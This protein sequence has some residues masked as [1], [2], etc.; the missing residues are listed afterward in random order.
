[1][2]KWRN[3]GIILSNNPRNEVEGII[4]QY[5]FTEPDEN[6]CFR[7]IAQV[8]VRA[9]AFSFIVFVSSLQ[10]ASKVARRPF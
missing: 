8:I 1:M 10:L 9:T 3:G 4:R 7:I 6:N 5:I 2:V